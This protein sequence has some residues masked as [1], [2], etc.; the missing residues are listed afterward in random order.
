MKVP[1]LFRRHMSGET[2][3]IISKRMIIPIGTYKGCLVAD[4]LADDPGWLLW[5]DQNIEG[6]T[7]DQTLREEA[8]DGKSTE[9]RDPRDRTNWL[10]LDYDDELPF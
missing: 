3:L 1:S 2:K 6:W 4:I 9:V 5:A 8:E 7:L 10:D